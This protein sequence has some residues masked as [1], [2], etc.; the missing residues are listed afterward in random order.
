[1]P[2]TSMTFIPLD[3]DPRASLRMSRSSSL[4]TS[5]LQRRWPYAQHRL[6]S[7]PRATSA[8]SSSSTATSRPA[9][10]SRRVVGVDSG[11]TGVVHLVGLPGS[12]RGAARRRT[13][14]SCSTIDTSGSMSSEP[15]GRPYPALLGPEGGESSCLNSLER[16]ARRPTRWGSSRYSGDGRPTRQVGRDPLATDAR[17]SRRSRTKIAGLHGEPATRR[18]SK[19]WRKGRE[20]LLAGARARAHP[21][22]HHPLRRPAV[23]RQR[24]HATDARRRSTPSR[25]RPTR[26]TRSSSARAARPAPRTACDPVLMTTRWPSRTMT[27]TA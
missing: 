16:V 11:N 8:T 20:A 25:T 15:L 6:R 27:R 22:P 24:D 1:M 12:L 19:A 26:S 2:R 5:R 4:D 17:T 7:G 18:S 14:T 3:C 9:S 23:A 10:R 21:G 13:S